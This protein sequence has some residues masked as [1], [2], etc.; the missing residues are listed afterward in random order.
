VAKARAILAG[1]RGRYCNCLITDARAAQAVLE[2]ASQ[3]PAP[4]AAT[5]SVSPQAIGVLMPVAGHLSGR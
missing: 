3:A 2:L 1:L 4:A 5:G